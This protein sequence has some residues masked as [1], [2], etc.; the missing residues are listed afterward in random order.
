MFD[1]KF[2]F[3]ILVGL[4][5]AGCGDVAPIGA[6]ALNVSWQ[7][8]PRGCEASDL[9]SVE[10]ELTGSTPRIAVFQCED[11]AGTIEN[12]DAGVYQVVVLGVDNSGRPTFGSAP[13]NVTVNTD[14]IVEADHVRLTAA[15]GEVEAT[16]FFDNG[17]VCGTNHVSVIELAVFDKQDYE[18]VRE[19]FNCDSGT[20]ALP[21]LR[22]GTY[23]IEAVG[24]ADGRPT[25]RGLESISVGRG[26]TADLEIELAKQ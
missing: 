7:V 25:Y 18:V 10:V 20:G 9:A 15:P 11:G 19:R 17:R 6:G 16:W 4:A 2:Y 5:T 24:L 12:L 3:A 26:E 14:V 8:S 1:P 23:V 13:Q 21:G 22:A